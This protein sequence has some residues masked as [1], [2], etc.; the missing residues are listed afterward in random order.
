MFD[1]GEPKRTLA[2]DAGAAEHA[3]AGF[4]IVPRMSPRLGRVGIASRR[5]GRLPHLAA[6]LPEAET[7]VPL[8]PF[9]RVDS[10]AGWGFK[11]RSRCARRGL[12]Y[13]ALE[14]GFLRSLRPGLA[15]DPPLSLS[16]DPVG[17]HYDASRPSLIERLL[18]SEG[19]ETPELLARARAGIRT[20]IDRRLSK[21]NDAPMP[22]G[23]L[24]RRLAGGFVL[25]VDQTVGDASVAHGLA[26]AGSFARM[27]EAAQRENPGERI[28]VKLHPDVVS[29]KRRG[30]L[31][32]AAGRNV[33][34]VAET[35]NPWAL[36]EGARKVYV[37]TSQLGAEAALAGIPVRCFGLPFYA[38][39]GLTEDALA[40]TRRTRRRTAEH[41]FAAAWLLACRYVDPFSGEMTGF[42]QTAE[43]LALWRDTAEANR[44]PTVCLGISPWKRA[45]VRAFL[46]F[47][48]GR[49][50]FATDA[51]RAIRLAQRSRAR[52]VVWASRE[53]PGLVEA[54]RAA[55]VPLLRMEDGF[56]RSAG[57]GAGLVPPASLVLDGSGIHYDPDRPSDLERLLAVAEFPPDLLARARALREAIVAGG[58]SKYNLAGTAE[59]PKDWPTDRPRVLVP[60]QVEDD[61]SVRRGARAVRSN[62]ALLEAVRAARPDAFLIWKPHPDVAAGLRPGAVDP[63]LVRRFADA[64]ATGLPITALLAAVDEVHTMTSLAGFEAL[65][66]G[67]RVVCWGAPFYAGWGLTEDR[68]PLPGRRRRLSLDALVAATLILYP[69]YVDPVTLLPCPPERVV[70][71]FA[72]RPAAAVSPRP[73]LAR[74]N[75]RL[76]V[77]RRA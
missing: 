69:R 25:V 56:I 60:G 33:E 8:H 3:A 73:W 1:G 52:L 41:L 26:D 42:E 67:V 61:A 51:A 20:L 18:S 29:G 47:G 5:L 38:G 66:R 22:R 72:Q 23:A 58:V 45:R 21:Y 19:W 64:E 17:V 7:I 16:L 62:A 24:A 48:G 57:L 14:D 37:V 43:T 75:A 71:R 44:G 35:V 15:G 10:V 59:V 63:A 6:F 27:L 49:V 74:L 32:R 65:L 50:R 12:P 76:L 4:A 55:G 40:L 77:R 13:L 30:Y 39:W 9:A 2:E 36:L 46:G 28:L 34:I 70:A 54:A 11:P 53:P 31:E 68:V